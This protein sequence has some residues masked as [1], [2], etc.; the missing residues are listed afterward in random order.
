M[1]EIV[2]C[3]G[4]SVTR[5]GLCAMVSMSTTEVAAQV[6]SPEALNQWLQTQ[7]ADLAVIATTDRFESIFQIVNSLHVENTL[8]VLVLLEDEWIETAE[9]ES[10]ALAQLMSTGI[11]SL[12]PMDVS[13]DEIRSAIVAILSGFNV[14]HPEISEI[15]FSPAA[16]NTFSAVESDEIEPLTPREIQV[17]NQLASGATNRAIAKALNIS[18]HTVKFH[19]SAILSKLNVVSRTEAVAVGIR[20]GLVML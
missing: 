12:L 2:I 3:A 16:D 17:L 9:T 11:V 7:P 19:I 13:A 18:E 8:S 1:A 4:H 14:I 20:A 10:V 15:L 5:A 6:S